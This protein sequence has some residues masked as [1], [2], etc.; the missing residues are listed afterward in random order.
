MFDPLALESMPFQRPTTVITDTSGVLQGGLSFV[1]RNLHPAARIKVPAVVQMEIVNFA[2][3]FLSNWRAVKVKPVDLL[4]DHLNSQA[5]QRVLLQLE[6]HSDVE[7]ERTFL[8]GDPL[9][10]AF[11]REEEKELRELNLSVSIRAYADR[12]ILESARQHQSQVS[13]GHQVL[14]LTSDQALARMAMAE[15]L[16]PLYFRSS[17]AASLFGRRLTGTNFHPFA[18]SI[19]TRAVADVLWELATIFGTARLTTSDGPMA[20]RSTP[21]AR[22]WPGHP[23]TLTKTFYG[24]NRSRGSHHLAPEG[25]P[26]GGHRPQRPYRT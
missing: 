22:I 25:R 7:L 17:R 9:R 20:C 4:M 18:G 10:G 3:R 16:S 13:F 2:D 14:L 23:I 1:A 26:A 24:W 15:G 8:L 5:G 11:Q 21:S 6:L 19:C 12:L